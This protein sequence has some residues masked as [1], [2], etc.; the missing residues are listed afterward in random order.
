MAQRYWEKKIEKFILLWLKPKHSGQMHFFYRSAW[1]HISNTTNIH[2]IIFEMHIVFN[3]LCIKV[4]FVWQTI[5][6]ST[7]SVIFH[8]NSLV[9]AFNLFE[10][11]NQCKICRNWQGAYD[12]FQNTFG[13]R[14][15]MKWRKNSPQ[16]AIFVA[17]KM[18][19]ANH[20]KNVIL[21]MILVQPFATH[22]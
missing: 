17:K 13:E 18:K 21:L 2:F 3:M 8:L 16:M 10:H 5:C 12:L 20:V 7:V 11:G 15:D 19:Q 9:V 14:N 4:V 22:F 1:N 6:F